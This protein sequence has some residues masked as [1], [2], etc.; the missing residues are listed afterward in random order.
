MKNNETFIGLKNGF[1]LKKGTI[2]EYGLLKS[3]LITRLWV[4]NYLIIEQ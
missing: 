3:G 1:F 2:N 4:Y